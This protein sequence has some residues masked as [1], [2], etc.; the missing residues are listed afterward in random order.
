MAPFSVIEGVCFTGND[1]NSFRFKTLKDT[2]TELF[3]NIN[4]ENRVNKTYYSKA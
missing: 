1:R 4:I 2:E 3:S